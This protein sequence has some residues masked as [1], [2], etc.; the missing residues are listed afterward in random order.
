MKIKDVLLVKVLIALA[1]CLGTLMIILT[2]V[3][4]HWYPITPSLVL[5]GGIASLLEI[6]IGDRNLFE[7]S[8][9]AITGI[10]F[11]ATSYVM[12]VDH[13]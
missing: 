1:I 5:I 10:A 4:N 12:Y 11:I 9:S 2:L 7:K 13:L 3:G 8:F 6:F